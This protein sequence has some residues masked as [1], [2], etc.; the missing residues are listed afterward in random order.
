MSPR[1]RLVF[2]L[3]AIAVDFIAYLATMWITSWAGSLGAG[4][5]AIVFWPP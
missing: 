5:A 3:G 4:P 1:S 2:V